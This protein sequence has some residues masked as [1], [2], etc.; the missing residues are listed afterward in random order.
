MGADW[1][2]LQPVVAVQNYCQAAFL[3]PFHHLFFLHLN[4]AETLRLPGIAVGDDMGRL[5]NAMNGKECF[6]L[7]F[8]GA[9]GKVTDIVPICTP[10]LRQSA[11]NFYDGKRCG[12]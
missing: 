11:K 10:E 1:P 8:F 6:Q 3:L 7:P 12:K 4:I 9:A 5:N 2:F